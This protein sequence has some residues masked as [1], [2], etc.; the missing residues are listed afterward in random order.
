M[1]RQSPRGRREPSS[2]GELARKHATNA[3][4]GCGVGGQEADTPVQD[5]ELGLGQERIGHRRRT[6]ATPRTNT[7]TS[8]TA[9]RGRLPKHASSPSS[10]P[11]HAPRRLTIA[12]RPRGPDPTPRPSRC[13]TRVSPARPRVQ[14]Q[15]A[16][17]RDP[18]PHPLEPLAQAVPPPRLQH[19]PPHSHAS[20]ASQHAAPDAR[21]T[22]PEGRHRPARTRSRPPDAA[23]ASRPSPLSP[24]TA[25]DPDADLALSPVHAKPAHPRQPVYQR[26]FGPIASSGGSHPPAPRPR[27]RSA[28]HERRA[29][30]DRRPPLPTCPISEER[31]PRQ[32]HEQRPH[33]RDSRPAPHPVQAPRRVPSMRTMRPQS[34]ISAERSHPEVVVQPTISPSARK[35]TRRPFPTRAVPIQ[36]HIPHEARQPTHARPTPTTHPTRTASR[37][38]RTTTRRGPEA[39]QAVIQTQR[40]AHAHPPH[41][42]GPRPQ[43][44]RPHPAKSPP[45]PPSPR[46]H[47]PPLPLLQPLETL[48]P[49]TTPHVGYTRASPHDSPTKRSNTTPIANTTPVTLPAYSVTMPAALLDYPPI[50]HEA[51]IRPAHTQPRHSRI[52]PIPT[53]L[54]PDRPY[55]LDP[56]R[57]LAHDHPDHTQRRRRPHPA[58]SPSS[59]SSHN[60]PTTQRGRGRRVELRPRSPLRHSSRTTTRRSARTTRETDAAQHH[61]LLRPRDACVLTHSREESALYPIPQT[62]SSEEAAIPSHSD[63]RVHTCP[64][65]IPRSTR[66]PTTL[67]PALSH[68]ARAPNADSRPAPIHTRAHHA[69]PHGLA[70]PHRHAD[71]RPSAHPPTHSRE[72]VHH[73][74]EEREERRELKPRS[75]PSHS[76]RTTRPHG[77]AHPIPISST[78]NQALPNAV[79]TRE[80]VHHP[81]AELRPRSR[82]RPPD[83]RD[84]RPRAPS[85]PADEEHDHDVERCQP[86]R[87]RGRRGLKPNEPNSRTRS[88]P[89]SEER[90]IPLNPTSATPLTSNSPAPITKRQRCG[91]VPPTSS[92]TQNDVAQIAQ[93]LH[94]LR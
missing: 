45:Y 84:M 65:A 40:G 21:P 25:H 16:H 93:S 6:A 26:C 70:H 56:T 67:T 38:S 35:A 10:L 1:V 54:R 22:T 31:D 18:R 80:A 58:S 42:R 44:P 72:A 30:R 87:T 78:P 61:P 46:A 4:A 73:S 51:P 76:S 66:D 86:L 19:Q 88:V 28:T 57:Q 20:H 2:H 71:P 77:L 81:I 60:P 39:R 3:E 12:A 5:R 59:V 74:H 7:P 24:I 90:P 15:H 94:P 91:S 63:A 85:H 69:H 49:L 75:P 52:P 55:Q 13:S 92:M 29:C 79:H 33:P 37:P 11:H 32:H 62:T 36:A 48:S 53:P 8:M 23:R 34:T 89:S 41:Q 68:Y 82:S 64:T 17:P 9:P 14:H 50:P 47:S 83:P 27:P 43:S